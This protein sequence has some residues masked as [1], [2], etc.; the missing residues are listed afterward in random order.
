[1]NGTDDHFG[2]GSYGTYSCEE[3]QDF[4]S[5]QSPDLTFQ[6]GRDDH[7]GIIRQAEIRSE[8]NTGKSKKN[9]LIV[10]FTLVIAMLFIVASYTTNYS[11][12]SG[13]TGLSAFMMHSSSNGVDSDSDTLTYAGYKITGSISAGSYETVR[14]FVST[15]I[16]YFQYSSALG[17]ESTMKLAA[18]TKNDYE[19][20]WIDTS[21]FQVS[22]K[23]VESVAAYVTSLGT[24]TFN[25]YM[26]NKVQMYVP[27]LQPLYAT[28]TKDAVGNVQYRLSS[29]PGSPDEDVAHIS[30]FLADAATVYEIVG[31]KSSLSGDALLS[32]TSW[33]DSECPIAHA[34]PESLSEY[35]SWYSASTQYEAMDEWE[36]STG[37]LVPMKIR[38][39]VPTQ[40]TD[41]VADT[42]SLVNAV[43][44]A[45][46]SYAT[47]ADGNCHIASI[48]QPDDKSTVVYVANS[49]T[50][51]E[52]DYTIAD[53]EADALSSHKD[54]LSDNGWD[55][56][57]DH[58]MGVY[59]YM[60]SVSDCDTNFARVSELIGENGNF[61]YSIRVTDSLNTETHFYVATA[62][63]RT[64]E[65]NLYGCVYTSYPDVCG[66]V[67]SN[68]NDEYYVDGVKTSCA[69]IY[70]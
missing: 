36:E 12:R 64:W 54:L 46:I 56:Y 14:D 4:T 65:F 31:P 50:G 53:W 32:F 51:V 45:T 58:H 37:L 48:Y 18:I 44:G 69:P 27:D 66:C 25:E 28:L 5:S 57:Q 70:R 10:S 22:G 49:G 62:G 61:S 47:S 7:H 16:T 30:I 34:L 21:V 63:L 23:S 17:C 39:T 60:N 42:L 6:T 38:I 59:I 20:H 9:V 13:F 24:S 52:L 26:H 35:A 68:R 8:I 1:M 40:S 43:T 67:E 55:R 33:S 11:M 19:L 29:S 3:N 2:K 41:Y 15:Y